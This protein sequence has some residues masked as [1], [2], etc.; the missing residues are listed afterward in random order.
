MNLLSL[1][2]SKHLGKDNSWEGWSTF[3]A[4]C[5]CDLDPRSTRNIPVILMNACTSPHE[6]C[7]ILDSPLKLARVLLVIN[8][9]HSFQMSF[10]SLMLTKKATCKGQ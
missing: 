6:A 4:L 7:A 10:Y 5:D 3:I 2:E 8:I 9:M 1:V